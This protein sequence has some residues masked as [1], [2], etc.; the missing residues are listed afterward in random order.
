[1]EKCIQNSVIQIIEGFLPVSLTDSNL[2][3]LAIDFPI[4][5]SEN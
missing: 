4:F 3:V 2:I 5:H 1:M